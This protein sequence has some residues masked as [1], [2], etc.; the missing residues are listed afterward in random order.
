V[1]GS[2]PFETL[3]SPSP[4]RVSAVP[5]FSPQPVRDTIVTLLA[6]AL[7]VAEEERSWPL[8]PPSWLLFLDL[9]PRP[10]SVFRVSARLGKDA[11]QVPNALLLFPSGTASGLSSFS[12]NANDVPDP[13]PLPPHQK[14]LFARQTAPAGLRPGPVVCVR[15]TWVISARGFC[16]RVPF[17]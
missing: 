12:R 9:R 8:P 5:D 7:I 13:R 16:V 10:P 14:I 2:L 1:A 17:A 15:Q 11:A 6:F 3:S 4:K